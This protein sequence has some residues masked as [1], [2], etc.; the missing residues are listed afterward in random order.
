MS[1]SEQR[2][3]SVHMKVKNYSGQSNGN[4]LFT[5]NDKGSNRP[6]MGNPN[7]AIKGSR[8]SHGLHEETSK[9]LLVKCHAGFS[10]PPNYC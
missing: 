6:K 8:I 7:C 9:V 4:G 3:H 10:A 5:W 2:L 1:D